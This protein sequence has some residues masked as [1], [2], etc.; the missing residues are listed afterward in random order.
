MIFSNINTVKYQDVNDKWNKFLFSKCD[1]S[2]EYNYFLK[3][4]YYLC[5]NNK[6]IH[7]QNFSKTDLSM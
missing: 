3:L 5:D 7:I 1:C 4:I 2:Y 6:L